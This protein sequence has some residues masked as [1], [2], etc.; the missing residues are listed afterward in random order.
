[1]ATATTP[2][3][4]VAKRA[5]AKAVPAANFASKSAR[6]RVR[7]SMLR[8][9]VSNW[10]AEKRMSAKER[11]EFYRNI[12][13][14]KLRRRMIASGMRDLAISV[15]A[16]QQQL[17]RVEDRHPDFDLKILDEA[18]DLGR[19]AVGSTNAAAAEFELFAKRK[20]YF[21]EVVG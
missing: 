10:A 4:R 5:P 7:K 3:P 15:E 14:M 11:A 8:A 16:M 13:R 19:A 12:R 9:A 1:M 18:L 2:R 6:Q 21:T 17:R 20:I